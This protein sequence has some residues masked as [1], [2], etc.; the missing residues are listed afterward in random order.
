MHSARTSTAPY[1]QGLEPAIDNRCAKSRSKTIERYTERLLS[2]RNRTTSAILLYE[3]HQSES[4]DAEHFRPALS[5]PDSML[6]LTNHSSIF[7]SQSSIS[8]EEPNRNQFLHKCI[9]LLS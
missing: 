5:Y 2:F 8:L 1:G 6:E 7:T 4:L 9:P 3:S